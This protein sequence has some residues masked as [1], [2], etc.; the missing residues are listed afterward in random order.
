MF[1]IADRMEIHDGN[2]LL[3]H[4]DR[5]LTFELST[6]GVATDVYCCYSSV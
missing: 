6:T 1:R 5:A 3:K 2:G 4:Y